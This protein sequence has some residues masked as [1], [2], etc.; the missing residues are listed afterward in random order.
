MSLIPYCEGIFYLERMT[1]SY[2]SRC[3]LL[4][5]D[6]FVVMN[7]YPHSKQILSFTLIILGA[8]LIFFATE[9]TWIGVVLLITGLSIEMIGLLL[10]YSKQKNQD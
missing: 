9:N 8:V 6:Y 5:G 3:K 7:I 10:R 2:L 4:S 1:G